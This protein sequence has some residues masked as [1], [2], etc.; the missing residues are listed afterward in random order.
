[1]LS[2][3]PTYHLLSMWYPR[4]HTKCAAAKNMGQSNLRR[5][6]RVASAR[7]AYSDEIK[8]RATCETNARPYTVLA[9]CKVQNCIAAA[10]PATDR[11]PRLPVGCASPPALQSRQPG[12]QRGRVEH[13]F[14]NK[15][16]ASVV[17]LRN[18]SRSLMIFPIATCRSKTHCQD[19]K[20]TEKLKSALLTKAR[21]VFFCQDI[22]QFC[23]F[24][25]T[26][27]S[28]MSHR[29]CVIRRGL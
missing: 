18:S 9:R 3:N 8:K 13:A 17:S 11:G 22:S 5:R 16:A 6:P 26:S 12:A 2:A 14:S 25:L 1:M 4:T 10:W 23:I 29:E 15:I 27:M 24:E 20:S 28:I 21:N 7:T 19:G